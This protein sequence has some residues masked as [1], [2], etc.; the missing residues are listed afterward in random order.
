MIKLCILDIQH[1]NNE[2]NTNSKASFQDSNTGDIYLN[3]IQDENTYYYHQQHQPNIMSSTQRLNGSTFD[4]TAS[5]KPFLINKSNTF[6]V[7]T[8]GTGHQGNYTSTQELHRSE[9]IT[10]KTN[11]TRVVVVKGATSKHRQTSNI[12]AGG[13]TTTA[14]AANIP[15]ERQPS[16]QSYKSRDANISYAY[17]NVKKYIEENDLMTP[18]KEQS[19]RKWATDVEKYRHQ[20]EKIE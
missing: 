7:P 11:P 18:E 16:A 10:D 6:N 20:F 13:V 2:I 12:P 4:I 15:D 9:T 5:R 19:I 17:T 14:T 8:N 3:G 1:Q